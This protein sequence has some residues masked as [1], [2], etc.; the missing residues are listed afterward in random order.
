MLA[1]RPSQLVTREE[2]QQKL[3]PSG[4]FV[5][6]E[7]GLN[8]AVNRLRD[9][10]GDSADQPKF[11][12]TVPRKG[13]RFLPEVTVE[14]DPRANDTQITRVPPR[15][16]PAILHTK[17]NWNRALALA[18][19]SLS[20][21]VIAPSVLRHSHARAPAAAVLTEQKLHPVP[22]ITYGD[23]EQWLPAFSPDGSRI[24]YSWATGEG[25]FL[26]VKQIGSDAR[27][28][29]TRTAARF[30]PGPTWSPDGRQI[31]F[32][33]ADALDDRGIFVASALGGQERRLRT[34]AP[35]R[36]P[37]RMVN[38]SPDGRWIAFSD[39]FVP[40]G[41]LQPNTRGP[42]AI[43]LISP[44]TLETRQLTFPAG[45]DFG[46]SAPAFSPDGATVAFVHTTAESRDQICTVPATGGTPHV[47]VTEGLWTN[48]LTWTADGKS[49]VF[50]R[51]F[52][53]G[54]SIWEAAAVGGELHRLDLSE[55]RGNLLEPTLWRGSLAYESHDVTQT[56]G[57][58]KLRPGKP[59]TPEMP[60]LS[61]R[62]DR[63]ARYSP[64]GGRIAFISDRTGMDELW[65]A[66]S[67]GGNPLQLT[68]LG[69]P[70][71]GIAWSPDGN[72]VAVSA[73]MGKVFLISVETGGSRLVFAGPAF[74]DENPSNLAFSR[75]AEALY[76]VTQPGTGG[77]YEL[78][79]VPLSGGVPEKIVEGI[80]T[81]VAES[82]DGTALFYSL[83]ESLT[84]RT[85]LGIWKK[86]TTGG[87]EQFLVKAPGLWDIG[88][89]GL[90]IE[91]ESKTIE[92]YT[93]SGKHLQTVAKLGQFAIQPPLSISP[94]G[95][96]A[97]IGYERRHTIEIDAVR[98]VN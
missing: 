78:F 15:P 63:A 87:P 96:F 76:L 68:H 93:L 44:E 84:N 3:W 48:G 40:K 61:T 41:A 94:D 10:L 14:L 39:E 21:V 16:L 24:A 45:K 69:T 27:L 91:S 71:T 77:K 57:L 98:G 20:I 60:V 17:A 26:E 64:N 52:A 50:D 30:P 5:D 7:N 19:V 9:V 95:R 47:V 28:R 53:G 56:I 49:L 54:F 11:I 92:L 37:Q 34:L 89:N 82:P 22:L 65:V 73:T 88:P 33:R 85:S 4:T 18:A 35:W 31:A 83:A 59:V 80:I 6:F 62:T 79:K 29:L 70:I 8:S 81:N 58:I 2:I 32:V 42:N 12:E 74:T 25:W 90:Y 66:D 72:F 43:Y 46:D 38:W 36:V 1:V 86:P 55:S 67:D 23:G 97:L 75:N 51:S 13:Y